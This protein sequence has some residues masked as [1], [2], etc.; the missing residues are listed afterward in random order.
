MHLRYE[1]QLTPL[2]GLTKPGFIFSGLFYFVF[3]AHLLPHFSVTVV[4]AHSDGLKTLTLIYNADV[5][6]DDAAL[7][8]V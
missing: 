2:A 1:Q 7:S 5:N 4:I 8:N 3:S 6:I